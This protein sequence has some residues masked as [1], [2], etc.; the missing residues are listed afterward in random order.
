MN[1]G[2][3]AVLLSQSF[4]DFRLQAIAAHDPPTRNDAKLVRRHLDFNAALG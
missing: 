1:K 4:P 3:H 2:V